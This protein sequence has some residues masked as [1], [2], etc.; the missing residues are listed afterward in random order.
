M[1]VNTVKILLPC[2]LFLAG[3]ASR[4]ETVETRPDPQKKTYTDQDLRK[5][6]RST[7]GEALEQVDPSVRV[8]HP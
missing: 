1:R 4:T 7:T 5:T 3:C 6:G 2:L 8:T